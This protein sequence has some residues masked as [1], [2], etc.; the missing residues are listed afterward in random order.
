MWNQQ[1]IQRFQHR[2]WFLAGLNEGSYWKRKKK[3][4][5][6]KA[7]TEMLHSS[8]SSHNLMMMIILILQLVSFNVQ[9][10]RSL[11]LPYQF[12]VWLYGLVHPADH[13]QYFLVKFRQAYLDFMKLYTNFLILKVKH[14]SFIDFLWW[15]NIFILPDVS[16]LVFWNTLTVNF[17]WLKKILL[18]T[19]TFE[20]L[21][22]KN[23]PAGIVNSLINEDAR[24][25]LYRN[26]PKNLSLSN[27]TAVTAFLRKKVENKTYLAY[28][29]TSPPGMHLA[30]VG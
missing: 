24:K 28:Y 20:P 25:D 29:P 2:Q 19:G 8:L 27:S 13:N 26:P 15:M 11:L 18:F 3:K 5:K 10:L 23:I 21:P 7:K 9:Q 16:Q 12:L 22:S 6:C 4:R 1:V 17:T 30:V 14:S